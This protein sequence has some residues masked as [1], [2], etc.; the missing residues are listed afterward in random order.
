MTTLPEVVTAEL[1]DDYGAAVLPPRSVE[2]STRRHAASAGPLGYAVERVDT[3]Q[4]L[5]TYVPAI[6]RARAASL[7]LWC[8]VA[9]AVGATGVAGL[10]LTVVAV[11]L[12]HVLRIVW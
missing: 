10:A 8:R 7:V 6:T 5:R 2:Q 9:L 4:P 3:A 12:V 11:A 1:V